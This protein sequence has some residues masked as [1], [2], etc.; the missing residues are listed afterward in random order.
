MLLFQRSSQK[1]T[2]SPP[3]LIVK[4]ILGGIIVPVFNKT[5]LDEYRDVLIRPKFHLPKESVESFISRIMCYGYR[6]EPP[7]THEEYPDPNDAVFYETALSFREE[8]C[9]VVTGNTKH[10]PS[11]E[12]VITPAEMVARLRNET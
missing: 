7:P 10:F 11:K 3:S 8:G 9:L 2:M 12:F 4:E 1:N 5:I 6:A